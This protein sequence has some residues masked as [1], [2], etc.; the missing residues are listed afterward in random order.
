MALDLPNLSEIAMLA[1]DSFG[2]RPSE[3]FRSSEASDR[4]L[5]YS[6]GGFSIDLQIGPAEAKAAQIIGQIL[7]ESERGFASVAGLL[8]DLVKAEQSIWSTVTNGVGEF[9]MIGVEIGQY[10]LTI[11]TREKQIRIP[12]LPILL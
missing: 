12:A 3:G 2:D 11:D 10:Q 7:Q 8:V 9:R 5:V 1:Y 6:A 4:Q